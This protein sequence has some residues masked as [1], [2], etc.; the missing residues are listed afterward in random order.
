MMNKMFVPLLLLMTTDVV[1]SAPTRKK[2]VNYEIQQS[3]VSYSQ[4]ASSKISNAVSALINKSIS[5][6][7]SSL[8]SSSPSEEVDR[9][10][11]DLYSFS[12]DVVVAKFC[13]KNL[14]KSFSNN[15]S[16]SK[17]FLGE[18]EVTYPFYEILR[19]K[20]LPASDKGFDAEIDLSLKGQELMAK[21]K[22]QN[23]DY[24]WE[25]INITK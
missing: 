9:A 15:F 18:S 2:D 8:D 10:L 20:G 25:L 3:D 13:L 17:F 11:F 1:S 5:I 23:K 12:N 6:L 19:I 4:E 14:G 7:K 24:K 22:D 21:L 16:K